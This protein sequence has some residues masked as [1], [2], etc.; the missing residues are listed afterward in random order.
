MN[1]G[2][3]GM[4]AGGMKR[5]NENSVMLINNLLSFGI[6]SSVFFRAEEGSFH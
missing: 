1:K 3:N 2:E 4:A 6:L 5:T